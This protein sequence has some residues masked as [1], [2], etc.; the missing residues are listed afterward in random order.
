M[1]MRRRTRNPPATPATIGIHEL[2]LPSAA[3]EPTENTSAFDSSGIAGTVTVGLGTNVDENVNDDEP[4]NGL[5]DPENAP[6]GA[7]TAEI[8][9][10]DGR[11][12]TDAAGILNAPESQNG[13]REPENAPD[14]PIT[15]DSA[16]LDGR[17]IA[18]S[19]V[20][21]GRKTAEAAET[22]NVPESTNLLRD[23]ANTADVAITVFRN[24][25]EGGPGYVQVIAFD[26]A[27]TI[28]VMRVF[29]TLF[30]PDIQL[31]SGK[32]PEKEHPVTLNLGPDSTALNVR[33]I[34][35]LPTK[36]QLVTT[37]PCI[38]ALRSA[39]YGTL[40]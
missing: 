26:S 30:D 34:L 23:T 9:A 29:A 21:D 7:R 5:R 8:G 11:N 1:A 37:I 6:D 32:A 28:V 2:P 19:V 39:R 15:A 25:D 35:Q 33:N 27:S 18:E 22:S 36:T 14:R 12:A 17:N 3:G 31:E 40:L 38:R 10:V 24:S 20:P 13:L 4:E 16:V